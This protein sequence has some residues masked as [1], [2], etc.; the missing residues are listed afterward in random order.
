MKNHQRQITAH[1]W[2]MTRFQPE[3]NEGQNKA[4]QRKKQKKRMGKRQDKRQ[5]R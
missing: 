1:S 3:S 5:G 4:E 2:P